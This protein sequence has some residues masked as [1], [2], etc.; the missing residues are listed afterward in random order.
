MQHGARDPLVRIAVRLRAGDTCEYCLLR[1]VGRFEIDHIIPPMR[2]AEYTAGQ[3]RIAEP[4]KGRRGPH[5]LD[6]YAWSCPFCNAAKSLQLSCRVGRRSYRLFDPR[7]DSW[8][9]HFGFVHRYLF[10]VGLT[11]IGNATIN[12]LQMN[13]ARLDGPLGPRHE[14]ILHGRYPPA[15]ARANLAG[16]P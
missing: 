15:W 2:W 1:T 13:D 11:M 16:L 12:A 14:A 9:E 6:N 5:H 3:V 10:V 4:R 8:V 7:H